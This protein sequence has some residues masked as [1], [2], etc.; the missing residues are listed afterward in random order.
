MKVSLEKIW[1]LLL[2][3]TELVGDKVCGWEDFLFV[4]VWQTLETG[5]IPIK[6]FNIPENKSRISA[7]KILWASFSVKLSLAKLKVL[8]CQHF[9]KHFWHILDKVWI[10][11]KINLKSCFPLDQ[12]LISHFLSEHRRVL[13]LDNLQYRDTLLFMTQK[14]L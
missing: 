10:S 13:R 5:L 12:F 1:Y 7:P 4:T 8:H 9:M 2:H 6:F 14:I 11:R 3:C